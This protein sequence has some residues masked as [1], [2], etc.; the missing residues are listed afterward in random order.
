MGFCSLIIV[1]V[2]PTIGRIIENRIEWLT[3]GHLIAILLGQDR[4]TVENLIK[5]AE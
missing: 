2:P 3:S 5:F 4:M 1:L